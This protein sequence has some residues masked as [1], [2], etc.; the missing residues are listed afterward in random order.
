[1]QFID[2]GPNE[3]MSA[4]VQV[5]VWYQISSGDGLCSCQPIAWTN[6]DQDCWCFY[7]SSDLSELLS[8]L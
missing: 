3:N 5:M 4:L 2:K 1:M 8:N 7:E 6:D